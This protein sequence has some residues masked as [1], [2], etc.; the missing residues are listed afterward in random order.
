MPGVVVAM[1]WDYLVS[2]KPTQTYYW[3]RMLEFQTVRSATWE[4]LCVGIE[5]VLIQVWLAI[6]HVVI[7][8]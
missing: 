7:Q 3:M 1:T 8:C 2:G 6:A 5:G 4:T